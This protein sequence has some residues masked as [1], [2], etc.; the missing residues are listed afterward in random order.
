MLSTVPVSKITLQQEMKR[1]EH[2]PLGEEG[3][4]WTSCTHHEM[5][6]QHDKR[7]LQSTC[8]TQRKGRVESHAIILRL[9]HEPPKYVNYETDVLLSTSWTLCSSSVEILATF[10][11][12]LF[13]KIVSCFVMV[14]LNFINFESSFVRVLFMLWFGVARNFRKQ[15]T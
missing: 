8:S 14:Y 13:S 15:L 2:C 5:P 7:E 4:C 10:S 1:Q 6:H 12:L 11:R 3:A 9:P